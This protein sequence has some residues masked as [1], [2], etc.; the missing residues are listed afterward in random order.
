MKAVAVGLV[1]LIA[2]VMF[3]IAGLAI[4]AHTQG[5][6]DSPCPIMGHEASLCPM[7][8]LEHLAGWQNTLLA[9]E[10]L[11]RLF[12]LFLLVISVALVLWYRV[13]QVLPYKPLSVTRDRSLFFVLPF[14]GVFFEAFC[15]GV[16]HP[17]LFA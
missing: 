4:F 13:K 16:L 11:P 7:S 1:V 9:V 3:G 8:L 15:S 14:R 2:G 5:D 17:K 12:I 10:H 6:I